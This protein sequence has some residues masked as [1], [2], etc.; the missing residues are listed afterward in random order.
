MGR[1]NRVFCGNP[2]HEH[3]YNDSFFH[4]ETYSEQMDFISKLKQLGRRYGE[5]TSLSNIINFLKP[6]GHRCPKCGGK[7]YTVEEY[8]AYPSGL[9]DSG[10]VYEAGYRNIPCDLCGGKG[11]T[12]VEYVEKFKTVSDGYEIK[13]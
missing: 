6:K 11:Y 9:P 2:E 10:F 5:N 12:D 1:E 7:G 3:M 13:K 4:N 8:N